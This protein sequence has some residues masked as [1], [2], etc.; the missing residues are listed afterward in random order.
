MKTFK[1]IILLGLL[2]IAL[3]GCSFSKGRDGTYSSKDYEKS[4]C[5]CWERLIWNGKIY[6]NT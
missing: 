1:T 4:P 2:S 3:A 6:K 5:A